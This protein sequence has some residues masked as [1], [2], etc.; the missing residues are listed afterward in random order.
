MKDNIISK[1]KIIYPVNDKLR[2]YLKKYGRDVKIRISYDDLLQYE[3]SFPLSD[4]NGEYTLWE[5]VMFNRE[6]T[7]D[8]YNRLCRIY[9]LL[10]ADGNF[11]VMEHLAV[12]RVDFCTFG[13]TNPFRVRIINTLNDNIDYFYMK[14]ADASRVYGLE[15]EHILSPNRINFL[16]HE[17][18]LIEEHIAGIPGDA[19][20]NT[21]LKRELTNKV[22]VAKEFVKF[23]ERCFVQL[24]GDMR[25]YNYVVDITPDFE[26]E[27]YRVRAIDFDQQSYE[28]RKNMYL[29]QFF[30]ENNPLVQLCMD[31]MPMETINQYQHEERMMIGK[32][33]ISS[34]YQMK[35]IMDC[36]LEDTISTPD[37]VQ[38]LAEEL[39]RF[40]ENKKFSRCKTM[41]DVLKL[42][43][44]CCLTKPVK[45]ALA[46]R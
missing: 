8:I 41:G 43:L 42:H 24:L 36:M 29:P 26:D 35:D 2:S 18:T 19:F 34:R 17:N 13:N 5:S 27:Q 20:I 11:K 6:D 40:H 15:L 30:K 10:K 14:R 23:N 25:A 31:L 33:L 39:G 4:K 16:V 21:Y 22:R 9:A 38:D 45:K 28:G 32:R 7:P 1:K 3:N 44:K 12:S 37:K 46:E